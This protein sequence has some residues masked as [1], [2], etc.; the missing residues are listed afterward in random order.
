MSKKKK[1][2]SLMGLAKDTIKLG[3]VSGIG[4]GIMGGMGSMMPKESGNLTGIVG[5]G[6]ALANI[7]NIGKI[8][9]NISKKLKFK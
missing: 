9:I 3:A 5:S 2:D 1:S 6:L 8:G 4:M 7:G